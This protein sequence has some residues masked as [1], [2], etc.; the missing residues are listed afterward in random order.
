MIPEAGKLQRQPFATPGGIDFRRLVVVVA[1]SDPEPES[2]P[3]F[4]DDVDRCCLASQERGVVKR[5][6]HHHRDQPDTR[7]DRGSRGQGGERLPGVVD[8]PVDHTQA[9]EAGSLGPTSPFN[10]VIAT[11]PGDAGREADAD[12]HNRCLNLRFPT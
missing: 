7:S 6:D 8:H 5:P 3:S 9:P 12:L 11:P 4:R 10:D 1:G 2:E